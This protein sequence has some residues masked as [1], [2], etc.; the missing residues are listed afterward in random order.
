MVSRQLGEPTREDKGQPQSPEHP[1]QGA[2]E[3]LEV[4]LQPLGRAPGKALGDGLGIP[5]QRCARLPWLAVPLGHR[6]EVSPEQSSRTGPA[7]SPQVLGFLSLAF[8]MG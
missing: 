6:P 3:K 8:D 5:A 1:D 7:L 2:K 4:E